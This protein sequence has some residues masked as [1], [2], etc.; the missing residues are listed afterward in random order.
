MS[1]R[2]ERLTVWTEQAARAQYRQW[3]PHE[4]FAKEIAALPWVG[5]DI[6]AC[7]NSHN[8]TQ[9]DIGQ[10]ASAGTAGVRLQRWPVFARE[11]AHRSCTYARTGFFINSFPKR[12]YTVQRLITSLFSRQ[13]RGKASPS[14]LHSGTK[15][16]M[17]ENS[18]R[19]SL[20]PS[21]S[22]TVRINTGLLVQ[23]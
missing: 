18:I 15:K 6:T 11:F 21:E 9:G 12:E 17:P 7:T 22:T 19:D 1:H 2:G 3:F 8:P 20:G 23:P 16:S 13:H 10:E 14:D 4:A 5:C